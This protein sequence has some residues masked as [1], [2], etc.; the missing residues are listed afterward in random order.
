[1]KIILIAL[2]VTMTTG[3]STF[4]YFKSDDDFLTFNQ[5]LQNYACREEGGVMRYSRIPRVQCKSGMWLP[6]KLDT[7]EEV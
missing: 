7:I 4:D 2:L 3:C 6:W 1:M 5:E